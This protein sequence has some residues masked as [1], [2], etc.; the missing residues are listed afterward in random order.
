MV[1]CAFWFFEHG[2]AG[3]EL[4]FNEVKGVGFEFTVLQLVQGP[5]LVIFGLFVASLCTYSA[6]LASNLFSWRLH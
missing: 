4:T 1:L 3:R 2:G 5:L 6:T